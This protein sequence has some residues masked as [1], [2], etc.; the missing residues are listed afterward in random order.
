VNDRAVSLLAEKASRP[1]S[2]RQ[3]DMRSKADET[4]YLRK[5]LG[6]TVVG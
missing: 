4:E 2:A 1:P 3:K 5:R 6:A